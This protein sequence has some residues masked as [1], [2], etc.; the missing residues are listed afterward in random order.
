MYV[1]IYRIERSEI[2]AT[3]LWTINLCQKKQEYT[4]EKRQ[5]LQKV[6]LGKLESYM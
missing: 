3:Y 1:S 2:K 5:I 4:M 6:V